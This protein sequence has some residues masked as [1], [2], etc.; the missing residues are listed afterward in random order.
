[1]Q[2]DQ[3]SANQEYSAWTSMTFASRSSKS[4]IWVRF[5][6]RWSSFPG[7]NQMSMDLG[8]IDADREIDRIQGILDSMTLQER[9]YPVLMTVPKRCLRIAAGAGVKPS[10]VFEAFHSVQGNERHDVSV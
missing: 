8:G 7:L 5:R 6:T 1:M 4:R 3:V 9:S 2:L 10:D